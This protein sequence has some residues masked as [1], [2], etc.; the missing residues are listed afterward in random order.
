MTNLDI[1]YNR[2]ATLS[3][4]WTKQEFN[5]HSEQDVRFQVINRMLT[6]VLGWDFSD[7][8]TEPH[9]DSGYIDYLI[10]LKGRNRLVIEAKK[11]GSV[12]IDTSNQRVANY[13]L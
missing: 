12:L 8:K 9:I 4:E 6:E 10:A 5:L 7:I 13:Q 3:A 11:A 1:A 2:F